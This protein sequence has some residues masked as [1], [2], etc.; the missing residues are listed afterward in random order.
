MSQNP[1]HSLHSPLLAHDP[2]TWQKD[3]SVGAASGAPLTVTK[4]TPFN[5]DTV[6]QRP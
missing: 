5:V 6:S 3:G 1:L 4:D 2:E